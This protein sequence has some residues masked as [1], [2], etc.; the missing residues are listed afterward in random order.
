VADEKRGDL[1]EASRALRM[2]LQ[3]PEGLGRTREPGEE[4]RKAVPL[5][6]VRMRRSATIPDAGIP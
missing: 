3:Y 2:Y 1:K 6:G 4:D 5:S